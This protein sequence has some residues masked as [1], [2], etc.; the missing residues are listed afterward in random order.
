MES[1]IGGHRAGKAAAKYS[2]EMD[3]PLIQESKI[4]EM[5]ESIFAPLKLTRGFK[6]QEVWEHCISLFEKGLLGPVRNERGLKEAIDTIDEIKA[7]EIPRLTATDYHELARTIGLKNSLHFPEL[8]ARCA[9]LRT[10]SRGSHYRED[11]PER[12]DKNWLKWVIAKMEGNDLKV[13]AEAIPIN[14]YPIRPEKG[15]DADDRH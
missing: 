4:R 7:G 9:L 5:R 2:A 8:L 11:Y 15:D 13:W 14:E 3:V 10:E 12:D 1:A 6:Y